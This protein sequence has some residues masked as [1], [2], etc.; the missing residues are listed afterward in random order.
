MFNSN[1][2]KSKTK[3]CLSLQY[4]GMKSISILIKHIC[5]FKPLDNAFPYQW[6]IGIVLE[7]FP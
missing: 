4:N 2:T 6:F 3:F 7:N 1:F 5:K